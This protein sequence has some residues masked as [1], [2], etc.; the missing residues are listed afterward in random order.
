M[1]DSLGITLYAFATLTEA[2]GV[3]PELNAASGC[4]ANKVIPLASRDKFVAVLGVGSLEFSANLSAVLLDFQKK[5]IPVSSVIA[6]GICGAYPQSGI[7][8]G[9]VVRIFSETVGD[10]GFNEAD[11]SFVPWSNAP[12]YTGDEALLDRFPGLAKLPA[13]RG[14]TVNCCTGSYNMAEQRVNNFACQV[15]SM[16]GAAALA[17][18]K[19]FQVPVLEIRAVSNIASTRDKSAWRITEALEKLR[20]LFR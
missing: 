18:C 5:E 14:L 2:R 15:E 13:V 8:V 20:E 19:A 16:E 4:T 12:T 3:F 9:E 1:A 11:E 17:I 10:L 6:L 7:Q